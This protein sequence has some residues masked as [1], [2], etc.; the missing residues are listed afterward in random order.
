MGQQIIKQPD[1]QYA[2]WSSV[3]DDFVALNCTPEDIF[4]IWLEDERRRVEDAV[5]SEIA[6]L[7]DPKA[8]LRCTQK[9]WEEALHTRKQAHGREKDFTKSPFENLIDEDACQ[10]DWREEPYPVRG[11]RYRRCTQCSL[12]KPV[13]G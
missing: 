10:H 1:G 9:S 6:K 12:V 5:T 2:L 7:N 13:D 4:E 3:V 8:K 11:T